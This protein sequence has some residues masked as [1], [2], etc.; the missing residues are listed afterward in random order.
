MT[1]PASSVRV[2]GDSRGRRGEA[3]GSD[4][5][6]GGR[7]PS[8]RGESAFPGASAAAGGTRLS[9]GPRPAHR[10]LSRGPPGRSTSGRAPPARGGDGAGAGPVPASSLGP[11]GRGSGRRAGEDG[12]AVSNLLLGAAPG[13]APGEPR[14]LSPPQSPAQQLLILRPGTSRGI[15]GRTRRVS[16]R[17]RQREMPEFRRCGTGGT[18]QSPAGPGAEATRSLPRGRRSHQTR[19]G[20]SCPLPSQRLIN[21]HSCVCVCVASRSRRGAAPRPAGPAAGTS[22]PAAVQAAAPTPLQGPP[23]GAE[24]APHGPHPPRLLALALQRK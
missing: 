9:P 12:G 2:R 17:P 16:G 1:S 19:E 6:R 3:R 4:P 5:A 8:L 14:A 15:P 21:N 22:A 23:L 18:R 13:A 11:G 7:T 10:A 20:G 24:P